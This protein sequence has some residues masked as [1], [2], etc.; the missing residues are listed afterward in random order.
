M[1][2]L[3]TSFIVCNSALI[4]FIFSHK[5]ETTPDGTNN[6]LAILFTFL[7]LTDI[8]SARNSHAQLLPLLFRSVS[9]LRSFAKLNQQSQSGCQK[10]CKHDCLTQ[11]R[12]V[13]LSQCYATHL[14]R[15]L[16][17]LS[18]GDF[19]ASMWQCRR[20]RWKLTSLSCLHSAL[21]ASSFQLL[22]RVKS[23]SAGP[24][25]K[26]HFTSPQTVICWMTIWHRCYLN[27]RD[28]IC[29]FFIYYFIYKCSF[30]TVQNNMQKLM[31]PLMHER[32]FGSEGSQRGR[33]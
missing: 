17:D 11:E 4:L 14:K 1:L 25:G 22:N 33:K 7:H 16:V 6:A 29:I 8:I 5:L 13:G 15:Q 31:L 3:N 27:P 32:E 26:L 28:C 21:T 23:F 18:A 30:N 20:L 12:N 9:R 19:K 10:E 24:R 2:L